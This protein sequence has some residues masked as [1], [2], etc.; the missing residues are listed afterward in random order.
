MCAVLTENNLYTFAGVDA[1]P[2]PSGTFESK[3]MHISKRESIRLRKTLFQIMSILFEQPVTHHKLR[4]NY[5]SVS[6]RTRRPA[7]PYLFWQGYFSELFSPFRVLQFL[8]G[9][10]DLL[11][12]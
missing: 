10:A 4:L 3:N 9:L 5:N 2:C 7:L 11:V 12:L 1:P 6:A 8:A